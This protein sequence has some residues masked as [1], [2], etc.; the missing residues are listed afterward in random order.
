MNEAGP[1]AMIAVLLLTNSPA[2]MIPP[3]EVMVRWRPLSDLLSSFFGADCS[4]VM[5]TL[6]G[7]TSLQELAILPCF[8]VRPRVSKLRHDGLT[9]QLPLADPGQRVGGMGAVEFPRQPMPVPHGLVQLHRCLAI[10]D[11]V[12]VLDVVGGPLAFSG[13]ELA[14][15][16]GIRVSG[17]DQNHGV[18][19]QVELSAVVPAR[20]R[21]ARGPDEVGTELVQ[22]A[23]PHLAGLDA[24]DPVAA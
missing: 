4:G 7:N 5:E 9:P 13:L 10:A 6:I 21:A 16:G 11:P 20:H 15:Q 1:A 22:I 18:D 14:P 23:E 17:G 2:P 19:L 24:V 12:D 3:M 8:D